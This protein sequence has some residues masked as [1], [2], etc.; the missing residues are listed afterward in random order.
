MKDGRGQR[1]AV[2]IFVFFEGKLCKKQRKR[3]GLRDG[4]MKVSLV[5]HHDEYRK[6]ETENESDLRDAERPMII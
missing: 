6:M 2:C 3:V 5:V 4:K 1:K